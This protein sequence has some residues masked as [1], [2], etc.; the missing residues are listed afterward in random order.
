ME[1]RRMLQLGPVLW[2]HFCISLSIYI[3]IYIYQ[4]IYIYNDFAV[5]SECSGGCEDIVLRD[6]VMSSAD[7]DAT[8]GCIDVL[9][10][11]SSKGRGGFIR[12]I[13]VKN[14]HALA[15]RNSLGGQKDPDVFR[16][17]LE[18]SGTPVTNLTIEDLHHNPHH[19]PH[20]N[21]I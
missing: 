17:D 12:N 21:V 8:T 10:V 15:L 14:V 11:K 2:A 5:G 18:G 19:N 6:S 3:Y 7:S 9:R 13:L 4:H 20:H 16:F 1:I